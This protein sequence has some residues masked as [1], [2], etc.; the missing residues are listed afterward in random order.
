VSLSSVL[1]F[2]ASQSTGAHIVKVDVEGLEP[3]V[4]R[5]ARQWI[6]ARSVRHVLIEFSEATR[7]SPASGA[8]DMFAFMQRA[9]YAV[10]DV[11]V[12][13]DAPLD[14]ARLVAGDFDGVPGNL[15]FSLR[16][17]PLESANGACSE[18]Y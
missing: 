3:D 10:S 17:A 18:P 1:L 2:A 9:G 11:S 14:Y 16:D 15:L 5:G 12:E 8:V 13:S 4:L 6:C 7:A